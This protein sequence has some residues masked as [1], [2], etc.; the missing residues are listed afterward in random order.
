MGLLERFRKKDDTNSGTHNAAYVEEVRLET[1]KVRA[2]RTAEEMAV[3]SKRLME[4][5]L[6]LRKELEDISD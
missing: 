1:A 2:F 4:M 6:E 3:A 5:A